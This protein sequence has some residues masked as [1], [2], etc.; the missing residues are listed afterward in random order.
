ML[1]AIAAAGL[2]LVLGDS[3][4]VGYGAALRGPRTVLARVG[5]PTPRIASWRRPGGP[6]A[7]VTISAGSN[8]S[9]GPTLASSLARLRAGIVAGDVVWI[10]PRERRRAAIVRATCVRNGDRMVDGGDV[11]SRDGVH[12]RSYAALARLEPRRCASSISSM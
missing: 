5:A 9:P 2:H 4:A 11:A 1:I 7:R 6:L 10:L 8:D 3:I 12:P